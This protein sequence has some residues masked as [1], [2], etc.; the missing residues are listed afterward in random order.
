MK[1]LKQEAGE[2]LHHQFGQTFDLCKKFDSSI[3]YGIK[4]ENL[5]AD[6]TTQVL[7][8]RTKEVKEKKVCPFCRSNKIISHGPD[9]D[10]CQECKNTWHV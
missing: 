7:E 4:L 10:K 5:M 8:K 6:F 1:T 9:N 2:Y 3:T